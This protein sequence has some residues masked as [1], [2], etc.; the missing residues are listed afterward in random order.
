VK[1]WNKAMKATKE[2]IINYY[3]LL[4][5]STTGV[6]DGNSV[7][8]DSYVKHEGHPFK[9]LGPHM[10]P[11]AVNWTTQVHS[12]TDVVA[13]IIHSFILD[14]LADDDDTTIEFLSLLLLSPLRPIIINPSQTTFPLF[15]SLLSPPPNSTSFINAPRAKP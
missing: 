10:S 7:S 9:T 2:E 1:R 4:G 14:D 5:G 6:E 13:R 8:A 11:N 15:L 3:W 12:N